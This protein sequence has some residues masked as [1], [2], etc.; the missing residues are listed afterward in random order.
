MISLLL[1]PC[2]VTGGWDSPFH[3]SGK[4]LSGRAAWLHMRWPKRALKGSL[5]FLE[6]FS[7]QGPGESRA[8]ISA[9][10]AKRLL[11]RQLLET[12]QCGTG[13]SPKLVSD[14]RLVNAELFNSHSGTNVPVNKWPHLE[15]RLDA[16]N[17][18]DMS[19]PIPSC[20]KR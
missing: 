16:T 2:H 7:F 13:N 4:L 12:R 15:V 5:S 11:D 17:C 19:Q 3:H 20:L 14:I 8:Q 9:P 6:P 1:W 18:L 10:T